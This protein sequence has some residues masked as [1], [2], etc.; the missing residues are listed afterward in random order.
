[1]KALESRTAAVTIVVAVALAYPVIVLAGGGPHFPSIR[2]CEQPATHDGNI[3]LVF[4]RFDSGAEAN[5]VAAHAQSIG[6]VATTATID[7]C[8]RIVVAASGY[9]TVSGALDAVKEA[10]GAGLNAKAEFAP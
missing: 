8:G 1:M 5:T 10:E 9:T 2:D 7:N 3:Q 4:G 6:F